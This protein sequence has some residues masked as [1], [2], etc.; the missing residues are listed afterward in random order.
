MAAAIDDQPVPWPQVL[1]REYLPQAVPCAMEESLLEFG[2]ESE[3]RRNA[4]ASA[5]E[6]RDSPDPPRT[7]GGHPRAVPKTT[8]VADIAPFM[9]GDL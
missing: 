7:E 9:R 3:Q 2:S 6:G 5:L 4:R 1:D 8:Y